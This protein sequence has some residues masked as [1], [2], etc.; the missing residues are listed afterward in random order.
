MKIVAMRYIIIQFQIPALHCW[1]EAPQEVSF[2]RSPHRHVFHYK[3]WLNVNHNNRDLEFILLKG[4]MREWVKERYAGNAGHRSCEQLA[5]ELGEYCFAQ[6]WQ[7][8]S[9]EV[10]EDGENAGGVSWAN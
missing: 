8:L 4:Q 7:P 5:E 2:L 9:I 6:G 10:Y 1:P 3:V